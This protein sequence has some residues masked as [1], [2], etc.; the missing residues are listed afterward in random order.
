MINTIYGSELQLFGALTDREKSIEYVTY[1]YMHLLIHF[2][3]DF[4]HIAF[5]LIN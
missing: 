4:Q 3:N 2:T 1:L 5:I